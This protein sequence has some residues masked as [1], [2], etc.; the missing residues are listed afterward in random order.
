MSSSTADPSIDA[1]PGLLDHVAASEPWFRTNLRTL[2]EHKTITPGA[3]TDTEIRAGADAA[4][5]IFRE[6]GAEAELVECSGT[7][8]V[9][10]RF[11]HPSPR[12][13]IVIYNHL[14]VQPADSAGW[15]QA[16]PFS[17]EVHPHSER[18]FLYR[19]RGSTD[20]KGPGLC[21][22]RAAAWAKAQNLPID[23]TILWETEEEIGSPNFAEIVDRKRDVLGSCDAVIV[24][25]TIW[26]SDAQPAISTGL[27]GSLHA[28]LR[29]KTGGKEVHSGLTGGVARNPVKELCA[30]ATTID[31]AGFW[32]QGVVPPDADEVESFVRAG[33]DPDYFRRAHDLAKLETDVPLEMMLRLWTRPTFEVHGLVGGYAG[34]GVKTSVPPEAELKIS[35]RLVPDQQPLEIGNRLRELVS[36]VA[37]DVEMEIAG[38][39]EPYRG[40]TRG[41]IHQAIADA[42]TAATGRAPVSIREGGSIGAVP[43]L[44]DKLGVPI[45]FLPLSLPDHGYHAPN[46][47]FDWRQARVGIEAFGRVFSALSQ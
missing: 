3:T 12:A 2:V 37:P 38:H 8:S 11:A 16:D 26:P 21:G 31:R 41:P 14:D 18:E 1:P 47:Y 25:D 34:A 19:G 6:A 4:C 9:L 22:L 33:F 29:L 40:S 17:F 10:G 43:I 35:F 46:E 13:R 28:I 5:R 20:D 42:M 23:I 7:P 24:S 30:L 32:R 39:L 27:R 44:A 36:A 45:H 15:S